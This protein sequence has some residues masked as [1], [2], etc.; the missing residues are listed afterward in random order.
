MQLVLLGLVKDYKID[1]KSTFICLRERDSVQFS[2]V[3]FSSET[4]MSTAVTE[5]HALLEKASLFTSSGML[6]H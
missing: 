3:Q 4:N 5:M 1:T 2:S 6:C